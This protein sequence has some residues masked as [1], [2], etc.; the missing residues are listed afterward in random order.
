MCFSDSHEFVMTPCVDLAI[1]N[2]NQALSLRI[3]DLAAPHFDL[4]VGIIGVH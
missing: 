4:G 1:C 3:C 2:E